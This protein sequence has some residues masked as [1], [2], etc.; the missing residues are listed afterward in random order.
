MVQLG[1]N[2]GE[3]VVATLRKT[4]DV[5]DLTSKYPSSQL[6]VL[7]LDVTNPLEITEA[8]REAKA[9]FGRVDVVFNNAGRWM[10]GEVEGSPENE[11]RQLFDINFWGAANVSKEA[12][13]FFREENP[14][15]AGGRLLVTS[16][17]G[18]IATFI[19][20]GYYTATKFGQF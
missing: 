10:L 5:D 11:A 7:K 6:L 13:R 1:L 3:R 12:V 14:A 8:F 2:K 16:S 20:N 9:A 4:S 19:L 15:G 18:G 17:D